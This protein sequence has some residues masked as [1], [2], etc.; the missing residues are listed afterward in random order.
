VLQ[1]NPGRRYI[2]IETPKI[3]SKYCFLVILKPNSI[4]L[5]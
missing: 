5:D 4:K 3:G 1:I 2:L